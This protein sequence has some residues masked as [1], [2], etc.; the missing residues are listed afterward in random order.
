VDS[1][2]TSDDN[3]VKVLSWLFLMRSTNYLFHWTK[4][5]QMITITGKSFSDALI[6]AS[7]NPQYD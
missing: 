2:K 5:W 4:M 1:E 3:K 6:L 7:T